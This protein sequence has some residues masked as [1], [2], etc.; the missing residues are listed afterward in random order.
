MALIKK[1]EWSTITNVEGLNLMTDK[2]F[3]GHLQLLE[4]I[5]IQST[6]LF[7][8]KLFINREINL[9]IEAFNP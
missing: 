3:I 4:L 2:I 7:V 1:F 5:Q 8:T 6:K 9:T